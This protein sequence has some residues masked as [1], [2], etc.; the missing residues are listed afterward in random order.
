MAIPVYSVAIAFGLESAGIGMPPTL[1]S[2]LLVIRFITFAMTRHDFREAGW[3][4]RAVRIY[5]S[6]RT[7]AHLNK[8]LRPREFCGSR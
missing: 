4:R 1:L 5:R 7:S 2:A 8:G 3:N 6:L